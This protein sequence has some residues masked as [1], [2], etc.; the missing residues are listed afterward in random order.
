MEITPPAVWIIDDGPLDTLAAVGRPG[1]LARY[2]ARRLLIAPTTHRETSEPRKRL[3]GITNADS[4]P[5]V[6]VFE[7]LSES[8]AWRIFHELH[9]QEK[10]TTN[11]AERECIAYALADC[12]EGIFVTA[13][14]R[15]AL[16]ALSELGRGRVAHPF[17]LWID[18]LEMDAVSPEDFRRLCDRTKM[19]DQGLERM[20][21][22]V[23]GRFP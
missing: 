5:L 9:R 14:R 3:I 15:A 7:I 1:E 20:P 19:K 6:E 11:A 18:L 12:P 21:D 16:T 2:R 10:S 4:T 17:D 13:D 8:E 22:R 23:A